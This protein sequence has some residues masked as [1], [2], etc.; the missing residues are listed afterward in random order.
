MKLKKVLCMALLMTMALSTAARAD[1]VFF[2][3]PP[4]NQESETFVEIY[5][6]E[7]VEWDKAYDNAYK[8]VARVVFWKYPGSGEIKSVINHE[9]GFGES[10]GPYYVDG[11]GRFWAYTNYVE[12]RRQAWV[13]V[14]DPANESIPADRAVKAAV[15]D[16]LWGM[17]AP[18]VLLVVG[19]VAV[20]VVL[21]YALFWEKKK[22]RG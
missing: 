20:T 5:K 2:G 12:G 19:V 7:L 11:E 16:A 8:G 14:S 4:R 21:I 10:G 18:A 15:R 6:D 9:I 3:P 1:V 13:C 17:D 22:K